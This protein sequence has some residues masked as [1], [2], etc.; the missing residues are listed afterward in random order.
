MHATRGVCARYDASRIDASATSSSS[1][2]NNSI[3][4]LL[5]EGARYGAPVLDL[6][7]WVTKARMM[8]YA[9][10]ARVYQWSIAH[11]Y[12][13]KQVPKKYLP[14][15]M[16]IGFQSERELRRVL[17]KVV[18]LKKSRLFRG[19]RITGRSTGFMGDGR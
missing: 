16:G 4:D 11:N 5:P 3:S 13:Y 2:F 7:K 14:H 17:S 12:T 8:D 6:I 18:L 9:S 15:P 1:R 10:E 19:C